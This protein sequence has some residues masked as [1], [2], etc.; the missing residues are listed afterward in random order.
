MCVGKFVG[1]KVRQGTQ[2]F[3]SA[4]LQEV[5]L[6]VEPDRLLL[7]YKIMPD[8]LLVSESVYECV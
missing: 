4:M 7:N 1:S 3:V 6:S 8:P 5:E 2:R